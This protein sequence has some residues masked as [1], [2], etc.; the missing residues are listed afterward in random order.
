MNIVNN[1]EKI[2]EKW[3]KGQYRKFGNENIEYIEHPRKVVN[4]LKEINS[5]DIELA[6]AWSHDVPEDCVTT[7][8]EL[9]I[10]KK[11]IIEGCGEEVWSL[12][13]ELTNPSDYLEN[14]YTIVKRVD[15][16]KL[17]L[18]HIKNISNSAKKIKLADRLTN[19]SDIKDNIPIKWL[20]KYLPESTDIL[21]A[22]RGINSNLE[23]RLENKIKEL[24]QYIHQ[25]ELQQ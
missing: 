24:Q 5:T 19:L 17:N 10:L 13:W 4:L 20:K 7:K 2:A 3:H 16:W 11:E 21:E 12:V 6:A 9:N 22:C 25:N 8:E 1:A 15:K 18:N 23:L 14:K